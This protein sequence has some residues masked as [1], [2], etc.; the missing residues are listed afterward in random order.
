MDNVNQ[1]EIALKTANTPK[2]LDDAVVKLVDYCNYHCSQCAKDPPKNEACRVL[3]PTLGHRAALKRL[4]KAMKEA[5][6]WIGQEII[7]WH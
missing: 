6:V 3:W 7:K 4:Y 5:E 1:V 2:Q